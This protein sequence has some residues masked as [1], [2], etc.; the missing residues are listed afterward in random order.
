M[1]TSFKFALLGC[2][3]WIALGCSHDTTPASSA[4]N[5]RVRPNA[6][7]GSM[8][9]AS[10]THTAA[11]QIASARCER[12]QKCGNIGN[13]KTY[14]SSQD[15]LA[16]IRAD[17]QDDLNTRECPGGVNVHELNECLGQVRTEA[18]GNPFDTLARM[19]ECTQ[20]QICIE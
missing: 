17:W 20:A 4:T 5:E 6:P 10:G 2:V 7:A 16:R 18:C 15:C 9:A 13:D 19:T 8:T 12:E 1:N 14:S 11:Q 3:G